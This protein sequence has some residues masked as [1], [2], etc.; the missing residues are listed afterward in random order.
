MSGDQSLAAQSAFTQTSL[1]SD[2]TY[3]LGKG[4]L[5]GG[6]SYLTR[7]VKGGGYDQSAKYSALQSLAMDQTASGD[8]AARAQA[9]SGVTS[10]KLTSGLDEMNKLRSMLSGQGLQTTNFAEQAAN[11][12]VSAIGGMYN[13]NQTAELIKG[14]GAAGASIYGAGQT[15]G[16]WTQTPGA[17]AGGYSYNPAMGKV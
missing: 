16:W 7:A 12:S 13:G 2:E 3:G 15:G 9:L 11:Q 14:L 4:A 1:L 17:Q 10:A 5:E 6:L 8:P